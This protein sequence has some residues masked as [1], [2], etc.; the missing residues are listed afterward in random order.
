MIRWIGTLFTAA[1]MIA[2][3]TPV[4]AQEMPNGPGAVQVTFIPGGAT[5]VTDGSNAD[6]SG[7]G[8]SQLGGAVAINVTPHFGVEGEASTALGIAQDLQLGG[9]SSNVKTP[10]L[11]NYSG[12][13]VVYGPRYGIVPF[14]TAGVGSLVTFKRA[15]LGVDDTQ[16]FL[17]GNVGGG[18]NWYAGRWGIRGDY[19]FI[20]IRSQNDAPAFFGQQTRYAHRVYGGVLLNL[21]R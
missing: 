18:V 2:V 5:F 8:N 7:F 11:L 16:A 4:Y 9:V 15:E 6:G 10:N 3:V 17:T 19:R 12:N 21:G 14:A 1:M 13:V 20:A